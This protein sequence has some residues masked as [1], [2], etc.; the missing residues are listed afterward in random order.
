[1]ESIEDRGAI[2]PFHNL[3]KAKKGRGSYPT[4]LFIGYAS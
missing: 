1:M 4:P 3:F 2:H